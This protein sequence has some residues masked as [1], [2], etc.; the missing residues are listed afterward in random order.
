MNDME[1]FRELK[2]LWDATLVS[3]AWKG[4][5][6]TNVLWLGHHVAKEDVATSR[7]PLFAIEDALE[8]NALMYDIWERCVVALEDVGGGRELVVHPLHTLPV[9]EL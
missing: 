8:P 3:K 7:L 5:T 9:K 2:R 6:S 1:P 4:L